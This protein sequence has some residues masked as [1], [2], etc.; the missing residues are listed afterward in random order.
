MV[1]DRKQLIDLGGLTALVI[2]GA[3]HIGSAIANGFAEFGAD[4]AIADLDGARAR[5]VAAGIQR[6]WAARS[7]SYAIDLEDSAATGGLPAQVV[8]D[9]G[10]LDVLVHCAALVGTS[11]L[12]GW[13]VPFAEQSLESWR[14]AIEINLTSAFVA[15]QAAHPYLAA[16]GRGSIILVSS[17]YGLLGSDPRLYDDT[18]IG[19]PAGYFASKGGLH[20]LGRWLASELAPQVRVNVLCPGGVA[21]HQDPIFVARYEAKTPLGRMATERDMVGPALFLASELSAY[22]TGQE[23]VVDG[24]L[25]IR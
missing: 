20:Q 17:I 6:D 21:R 2:G 24:G 15:S 8:A 23:I 12:A 22:M 9:F 5:D 7:Q 13:S 18:D 4:V 3:G 11:A 16:S 1:N 14:R 10:S 25:T 19:R